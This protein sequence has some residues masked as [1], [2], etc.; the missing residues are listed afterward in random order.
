MSTKTGII[1]FIVF[2]LFFVVG[3]LIIIGAN[4]GTTPTYLS[5]QLQNTTATTSTTSPILDPYSYD[6]YEVVYEIYGEAALANITIKNPS[7][8]LEQY[9]GVALPVVYKYKTYGYYTKQLYDL[10]LSA[11][12]TGDAGYIVAVV[13]I[14]GI[15]CKVA[16]NYQ[17]FGTAVASYTGP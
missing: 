17:P 14:D 9:D 4:E 13:Y 10:Y 1:L 6:D 11:T 5:T 12:N 2:M 7:G 8:V 3:G 16:D 15:M